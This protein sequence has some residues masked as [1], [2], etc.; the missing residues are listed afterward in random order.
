M[1]EPT[2]TRLRSLMKAKQP[3]TPANQVTR[4]HTTYNAAYKVQRQNPSTMEILEQM[5]NHLE[6]KNDHK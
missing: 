6:K 2:F 4:P 3:F 1:F 5:L